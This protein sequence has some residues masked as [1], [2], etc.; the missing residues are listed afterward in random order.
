MRAAV[1]CIDGEVKVVGMVPGVEDLKTILIAA[2]A[3]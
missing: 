2:G 3:P 1:L